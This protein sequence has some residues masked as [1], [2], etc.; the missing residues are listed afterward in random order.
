MYSVLVR[1]HADG[2][3]TPELP[4]CM[5]GFRPEV[6]DLAKSRIPRCTR[7]CATVSAAAYTKGRIRIIS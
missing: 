6:M 3:A 5:V 1:F 7:I 4:A 2:A